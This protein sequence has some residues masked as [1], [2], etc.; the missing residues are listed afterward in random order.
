MEFPLTGPN[1]RCESVNSS[2]NTSDSEDMEDSASQDHVKMSAQGIPLQM[3]PLTCGGSTSPSSMPLNA[4][5]KRVSFTD[6]GASNVTENRHGGKDEVDD[7]VDKG[8]GASLDTG[9]LRDT[10]TSAYK[11]GMYNISLFLCV[12][13]HLSHER[14]A[15][16]MIAF[17]NSYLHMTARARV[18]RYSVRTTD[19]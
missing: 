3:R 12:W 19:F 9:F 15:L 10:S 13:F 7:D 1:S 11:Q 5:Q 17:F 16:N 2:L 4:P 14:V 8:A 18:K 6:Q